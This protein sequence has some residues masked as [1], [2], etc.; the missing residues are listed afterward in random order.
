MKRVI[1]I[2]L[3][4]ASIVWSQESATVALIKQFD[5][6]WNA[7]DLATIMSF[8]SEDATFKSPEGTLYS[9]KPQ[10]EGYVKSLLPG[11][12]V[13]TSQLHAVGDKA[14]WQYTVHADAFAQIGVNPVK[15]QCEAL[16][17]NNQIKTFT[18]TSTQETQHKVAMQ[19][20]ISNY[21]NPATRERY[22]E[23]YSDNC[24]FHDP[25]MQPGLENIKKF[26][27]A[28]WSAFPDI[29]VRI[30]DMVAEGDKISC[31]FSLTATHQGDFM[32]MPATGKP[33]QLGGQT[34]LRFENG[35]CVD[36]WTQLD[37]LAMMQ[38]LGAQAA[39][40]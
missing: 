39:N 27:Q 7:R 34:I 26:Y 3:M 12:H 8:F 36:R 15:G 2:V 25:G 38:Q 10:I 35:K 31:R 9:G 19:Q 5:A 1:L 20:A 22:F 32:G 24:V 30:D 6:A 13:E 33:V 37:N 11:F 40:K 29:Q 28:F 21:N 18:A 16:I 17:I 14:I 23:L 4:L